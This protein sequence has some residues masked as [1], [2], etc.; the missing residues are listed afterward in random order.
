[1]LRA[2]CL[3]E[4]RE[5]YRD[6]DT[7]LQALS[8]ADEKDCW[9]LGSPAVKVATREGPLKLTWDSKDVRHLDAA[10][11]LLLQRNGDDQI[12]TERSEERERYLI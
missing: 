12:K 4:E 10:T 1:V 7:A 2:K 5:Q 8:E 3:L 6:N 9:V 11:Q